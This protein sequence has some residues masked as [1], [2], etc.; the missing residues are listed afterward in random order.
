MSDY[1]RLTHALDA[2]YNPGEQD[3][4]GGRDHDHDSDRYQDSD[5]DSE[6]DYDRYHDSDSDGIHGGAEPDVT[7]VKS[8]K[9]IIS[10]ITD[11]L[12]EIKDINNI[13]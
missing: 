8:L 2:Y 3:Y 7:D 13:S 4:Y 5:H 9:G 10:F 12:K 6:Y 1:D 11:Y